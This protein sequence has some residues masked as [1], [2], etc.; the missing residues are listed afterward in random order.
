MREICACPCEFLSEVIAWR[1]DRMRSGEGIE[2]G[3]E[4]LAR[5]SIL[6][7]QSFSI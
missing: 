3:E 5:P 7:M 4:S 2:L 6:A 1:R